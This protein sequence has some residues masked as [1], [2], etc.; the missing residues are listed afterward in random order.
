MTHMFCFQCEQTVGDGCE[1]KGNC[2]KEGTT[3]ALQDLMVNELKTLSAYARA[4]RGA[5]KKDAEIDRFVIEVL[6][7]TVTNV[8]F[9]DDR[10]VGQLK[11]LARLRD[12]AAATCKEAGVE[13]DRKML[14]QLAV[15]DPKAFG[16]L[17]ELAKSKAA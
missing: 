9:D 7:T 1:V 4:A 13:V 14:A 5:G 10:L 15:E 12:R 16:D 11:Q 8:S 6:F 3:A 2:G 17:A